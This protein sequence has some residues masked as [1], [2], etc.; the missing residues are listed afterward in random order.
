MT[1]VVTLVALDPSTTRQEGAV[2]ARDSS[3]RTVP[4]A[5]RLGDIVYRL[6]RR[7]G[8]ASPSSNQSRFDAV[9]GRCFPRRGDAATVRSVLM[10]VQG[11]AFFGCS[12]PSKASCRKDR[13]PR[14]PLRDRLCGVSS[15]SIGRDHRTC[16]RRLLQKGTAVRSAR[17]KTQGRR[18]ERSLV[19]PASDA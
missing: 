15:R 13:S 2:Y 4:F 9:T 6:R 19:P 11:R 3:F 18:V 7:S 17:R 14:G 12:R 1:A 10:P 5:H 8:P 16:R